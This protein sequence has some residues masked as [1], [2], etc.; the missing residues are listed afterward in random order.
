MNPRANALFGILFKRQ[1]GFLLLNRFDRLEIKG[2]FKH[3]QYFC[4]YIFFV[5]LMAIDITIYKLAFDSDTIESHCTIYFK[6]NTEITIIAVF[7]NIVID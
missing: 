7:V 4:L 5:N 2:L 1:Y 6:N 3:M